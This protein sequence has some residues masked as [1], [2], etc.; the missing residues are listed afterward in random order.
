MLTQGSK[1][2]FVAVAHASWPSRY[3][4]VDRRSEVGSDGG[5]RHRRHGRDGTDQQLSHPVILA[6]RDRGSG[7]ARLTSR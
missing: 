2:R 6:H 3:F 1:L 7:S 5:Q 4:G